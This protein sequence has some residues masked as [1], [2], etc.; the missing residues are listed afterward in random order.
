MQSANLT[1]VS[2]LVVEDDPLAEPRA[3]LWQELARV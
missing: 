1:G 3:F 2:A